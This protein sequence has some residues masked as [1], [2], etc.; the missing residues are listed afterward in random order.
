MM[1]Y[2]DQI[3]LQATPHLKVRNV[4][5]IVKKDGVFTPDAEREFQSSFIG[6]G[7]VLVKDSVDA[8]AQYINGV[9]CDRNGVLAV[10]SVGALAAKQ[11]SALPMTVNGRIAVVTDGAVERIGSGAT[12]LNQGRLVLGTGSPTRY[13]SG[14]PYT[15]DSQIA[16]ILK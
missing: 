5:M 3:T 6:E 16:V 2:Y 4:S 1:Y 10:D 8:P 12:P 9:P 13:S 7:S 11:V 14:V 15:A